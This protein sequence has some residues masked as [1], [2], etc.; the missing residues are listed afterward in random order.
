MVLLISSNMAIS[1]RPYWGHDRNVKGGVWLG[2]I[3]TLGLLA[4]VVHLAMSNHTHARTSPIVE[5]RQYRLHPGTRDALIDLFER[6][7]IE[8]QEAVGMA[9][10]GTF[11]DVDDPDR[12]VWLR[13]FS[14]MTSRA[15]ALHAFYSGPVWQA[16]RNAANATMVDS[17]DVLLL[18]LVRAGPNFSSGERKRPPRGAAAVPASLVVANIYYFASNV[19]APFIEFFERVLS[20]ALLAADIPVA[21]AYVSETSPNNFPPLPV[22]ENERVFVWFS[23]HRDAGAYEHSLARL[24]QSAEWASIR[25]QLRSKLMREPEVHRLQ[26][27]PRSALRG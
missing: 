5:L 21:A 12:F 7:F 13:G 6:E 17:D 27:T 14:D 11:R 19:G 1:G 9:I 3:A 22:R 8:S 25:E 24:R 15:N 2:G 4:V 16:H 18:R 23:T 26:P 20:P 10:L